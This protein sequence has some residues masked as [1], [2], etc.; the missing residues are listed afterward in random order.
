MKTKFVIVSN[1]HNVKG[2]LKI[3]NQ[4]IEQIRQFNYLGTTINEDWDN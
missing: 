4:R 3:K 2:L 1:N